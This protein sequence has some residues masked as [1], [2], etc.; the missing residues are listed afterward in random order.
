MLRTR[1]GRFV[2]GAEDVDVVSQITE[3][4]SAADERL[5]GGHGLTTVTAYRADIAAH[6][7]GQFRE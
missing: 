3:A 6:A 5:G 2:V 1:T 7:P 4:F